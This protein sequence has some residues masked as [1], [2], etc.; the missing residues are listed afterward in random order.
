MSR[1]RW[2][3]ASAA[4]VALLAG[5]SVGDIDYSGKGCS[6]E[7]PCP[8]GFACVSSKCQKSAQPQACTPAFTVTGFKRV[9]ETPHTVRWGWTPQGKADDFV[10]YKLVLGTSPGALDS[11]IQL[12]QSGGNDGPGGS[13]WTQA[14]SPELGQYELR[15]SSGTDPITA[16]TTDGLT[17]G[18]EYQARLLVYDAS[19]CVFTTDPVHALTS[20]PSGFSY[21]LFDDQPHPKGQ[22]RPPDASLQTDATQA[23]D[24]QRYIYWPGWPNDG[25]VTSGTYEN[26]GIFS[27]GTDPAQD[28]P[29]MDFSAA[30]L[31]LAV[32]VNGP[33]LAAWGE[34][35]LISGPAPGDCSSITTASV[36][37]YVFRPGSG[38]QVLE[39]PLDQFQTGSGNLDAATMKSTSICEVSV[40]RSW[41]IGESV[42][43]D[44]IR[45]RW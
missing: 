17:P 3:S 15:L 34:V 7:A 32:A 40:G 4:I 27:I 24:G 36:H 6:V 33:A 10:Q 13:V 22:A 20:E 16:T 1:F 8:D 29:L 2:L 28:Y 18:T 42:R 37:P 14:D 39:L 21:A 23:F 44:G 30:Y 5:C 31:E 45:L 11:A 19:G 9:W 35:R 25:S 12:A 26:V 38:Y 43:V 41:A